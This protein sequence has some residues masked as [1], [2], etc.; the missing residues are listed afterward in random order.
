VRFN[1][2][3]DQLFLTCSSDARLMLHNA[4]SVSSEASDL[5]SMEILDDSTTDDGSKNR[6]A[7]SSAEK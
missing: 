4:T 3:H 2:V 5:K 6:S 7:D 1:P